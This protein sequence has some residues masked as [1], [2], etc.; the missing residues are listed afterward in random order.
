MECKK[1]G[2]DLGEGDEY[3]LLKSHIYRC[4]SKEGQAYQKAVD[5]SDGH[6]MYCDCEKCV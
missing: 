1:C 5:D 3:D 4:Q 6:T 2:E